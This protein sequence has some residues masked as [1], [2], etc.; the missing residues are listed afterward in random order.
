MNKR[1][2]KQSG[3]DIAEPRVGRTYKLWSERSDKDFNRWLRTQ[4]FMAPLYRTAYTISGLILLIIGIALLITNQ[5]EDA[6][7]F[8]AIGLGII[9]LIIVG[10]KIRV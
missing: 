6:F 7:V 2:R 3:I 1:K 4:S 5:K 8:I 9:L 10:S